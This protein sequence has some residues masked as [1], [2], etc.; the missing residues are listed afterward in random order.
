MRVGGVLVALLTLVVYLASSAPPARS[1]PGSGI[2][3]PR[4]ATQAVVLGV[5]LAHPATKPATK[6]AVRTTAAHKPTHTATHKPSTR[7]STRARSANA[8]CV[9]GSPCRLTSTRWT[10]TVGC[11]RAWLRAQRRTNPDAQCPPGRPLLP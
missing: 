10:R 2:A 4:T 11:T 5:K 7:T 9:V 3:Q 6:P 8:G 1:T